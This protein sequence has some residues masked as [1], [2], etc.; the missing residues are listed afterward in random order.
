MAK[1]TVFTKTDKA[2]VDA[3]KGAA[4]G[5]TLAELNEATGMESNLDML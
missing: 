3:L 2:I 1:Q 5:L 4:D